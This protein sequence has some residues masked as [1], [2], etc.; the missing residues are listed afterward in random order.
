MDEKL[1]RFVDHARDKG[2]DHATIRQLLLPAG[3]KEKDIAE[4]F[5]TRD[6][7]LSIPE[8]AGV[9]S[10]RARSPR[11]PGV[12]RKARDAFLHLL[13]YGSL[14]L[15]ATSLILLLLT[16]IDFAF[17]DPA[18]RT[19][20]AQLQEILSIIRA[21]LAMV[22]VSFPVF[23]IAWNFL[24][25]EVRRHPETG[26]GVLRRWLG[27]LS[28]FVG[29]ITLSGDAMTLIYYLLEGQLTLRFVLK[30]AVLFLIAG[31]LV[32]YLAFTLRSETQV[33]TDQ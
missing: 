25:R 31:G 2:L 1:I 33:P 16:Y 3:W 9:G 20:Y 18:W 32:G 5:C 27:Y 10:S 24:L 17:P 8:P 6:L 11:R 30:A 23:L 19:S 7:E 28:L 26:R 21:Q 14:Y 4:V 22:V 12:P 15:W 13:T 29:A